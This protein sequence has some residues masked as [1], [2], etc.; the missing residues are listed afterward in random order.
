MD[1]S[2]NT[3]EFVAK[4]QRRRR[5]GI[6]VADKHGIVLPVVVVNL[7]LLERGW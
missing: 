7:I 5:T 3:F 2:Q 1:A 6:P 4:V